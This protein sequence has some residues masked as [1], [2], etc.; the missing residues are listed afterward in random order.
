MF[1]PKLK[2]RD[3]LAFEF[4]THDC[5][6]MSSTF[7]TPHAAALKL[8]DILVQVKLYER[9]TGPVMMRYEM[10]E[11]STGVF[12]HLLRTWGRPVCSKDNKH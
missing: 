2:L 11:R 6:T 7:W 9:K 4:R 12:M 3:F 5:V 8:Y 1:A 10:K